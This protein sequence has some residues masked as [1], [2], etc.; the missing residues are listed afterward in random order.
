MSM[1][2]KIG[3]IKKAMKIYEDKRSNPGRLQPDQI[4]EE[5]LNPILPIYW[6]VFHTTN[7]SRRKSGDLLSR[8]D[9]HNLLPC[10]DVGIFLVGFSSLPIALSLAEIDPK[11]EIYFIYSKDTKFVLD[12]IHKRIKAMLKTTNPSLVVCHI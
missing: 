12:E 4:V 3:E 11:E 10:Y 8:E 7:I 1:M 5:Y 2:Q 6:Q 9:D